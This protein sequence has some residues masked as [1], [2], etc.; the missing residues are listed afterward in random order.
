M[1]NQQLR[2]ILKLA[3]AIYIVSF[4]VINWDDVSWIFNYRTVYGMIDGFFNPYPGV[5]ASSI[6]PYFFPNHSPT[7]TA[8]SA[9]EFKTKPTERQNILEIP[10]LSLEVPM[11]LSAT[12]DKNAIM[13]DLDKGVVYY[14]G[15]VLPG[16]RG[17]IVV[18][19]HSAPSGWPKVKYDWVFSNL[20]ELSSGD[21]ILV[22][23]NGKQYAYAVKEKNIVKRGSEVSLGSSA[24]GKNVLILISCWPPGKDYQRIAVLAELVDNL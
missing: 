23:M 9:G 6:E 11:V 21:H 8:Q 12:A 22:D 20:D 5:D 19:G 4:F 16:Q 2:K 1:N 3:L 14:P 15:S 10:R 13:N 18:L 24:Q 7:G 17:Q